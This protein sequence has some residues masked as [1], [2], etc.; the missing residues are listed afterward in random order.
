MKGDICMVLHDKYR[1]PYVVLIVESAYGRKRAPDLEKKKSTEAILA[2]FCGKSDQMQQLSE[3]N[4]E[5]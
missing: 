2:R 3:N 1:G 5:V 4:S